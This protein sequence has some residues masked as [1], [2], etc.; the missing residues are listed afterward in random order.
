FVLVYYSLYF[1]VDTHASP[2]AAET[3]INHYLQNFL[4]SR[5]NYLYFHFLAGAIVYIFRYQVPYSLPLALASAAFIL[6]NGGG[7]IPLGAA[8]PLILALPVGYL[9]AYLGLL[10]MKKMPL[11]SRGDYSYGMYLY[12]YPIQQLLVSRFPGHFSVVP[13]FILS[14][15]LVTGVAM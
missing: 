13:H 11:F 3:P 4:S 12:A 9:T 14:T 5:G 1:C 6:L 8:K 10:P 7:V 15:M 2:L